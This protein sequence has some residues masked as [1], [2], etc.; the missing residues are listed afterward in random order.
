[1]NLLV[2]FENEFI[3]KNTKSDLNNISFSSRNNVT[4][5]TLRTLWLININI[6]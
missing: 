6:C 3:K 1:M 2:N 4:Q 5:V